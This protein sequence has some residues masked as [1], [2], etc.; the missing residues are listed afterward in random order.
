[1][2]PT[3]PNLAP[4][5]PRAPAVRPL[6]GWPLVALP[7][8][9]GALAWPTLEASVRQTIQAI[10][11]TAPG[12]Q[13]MRPGFGGGLE[14]LLHEP[15]TVATRRRLHD[16]IEAALKSWE[17]RI[18]LDAIDIAEVENQ[19]SA[20]RVTIAYRLLRTGAPATLGLAVTLT[21]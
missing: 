21:G 5:T 18:V 4:T 3:T 13:L 17:R 16:A 8:E 14:T 15:N 1:M 10:L 20:L 19:P 7:D 12:E 9:N 11:A 2:S 6:L